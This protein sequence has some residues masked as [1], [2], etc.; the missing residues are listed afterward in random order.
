MKDF[1]VLVIE[2]PLRTQRQTPGSFLP[3]VRLRRRS[4]GS[5]QLR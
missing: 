4:T 3:G 2:K 5:Y 1:P